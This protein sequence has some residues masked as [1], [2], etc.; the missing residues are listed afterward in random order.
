MLSTHVRVCTR[1]Q[2]KPD[3]DADDDDID[4][5]SDVQ[6]ISDDE[7]RVVKVSTAVLQVRFGLHDG[8]CWHG[9]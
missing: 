1:V 5:D 7:G 3:S 4:D 2:T 6:E 8:S 9:G